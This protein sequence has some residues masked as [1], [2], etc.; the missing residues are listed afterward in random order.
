MTAA[1]IIEQLKSCLNVPTGRHLYG[2][3]G[4]YAELAEFGELLQHA[5]MPGGAPFPAPRSVNRGVL[6]QIP[7][8]KFQELAGDEAKYPQPVKAH[9]KDAFERF[10][11]G[12][13]AEQGT[14]V[15]SGL[16]ILF[17]YR[18]E[19][20]PLR[21]LS[22]DDHRAILLLPGHRGGQRVTMYPDADE[23]SYQLPNQLIAE[24]HLWLLGE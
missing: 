13:Y 20:A 1:D 12:A 16:E 17:A 9:I 23:G 14:L 19:L 24:N 21:T 3:L 11:R 15:L 5:T 8:A 2:V 4:S 22:R 18:L 7:E 10:L 6:E